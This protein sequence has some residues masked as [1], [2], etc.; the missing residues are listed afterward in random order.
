M[1]RVT[2][3][4]FLFVIVVTSAT[5]ACCTATS[6]LPAISESQLSFQGAVNRGG[7]FK[8]EIRPGLVFRLN[9]FNGDGEGWF[10]Q[11]GDEERSENNFALYVTG[12]FHGL[13]DLVIEGWHFR[14][15]DNTGPRTSED[16]YAPQATRHFHFVLNE[17]DNQVAFDSLQKLVWSYQYSKEEVEQARNTY[18]Q[19]VLASGVL[20]ITEME[21]GNLTPREQAFIESMSF[22]VSLDLPPTTEK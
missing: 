2:Q 18:N 19:L 8:R 1:R 4:I 22:E 21:L 13:N 9:D 15:A 10:I 16:R 7:S 17:L 20:T 14:N 6:A 5:L 3:G 11:V 12:P